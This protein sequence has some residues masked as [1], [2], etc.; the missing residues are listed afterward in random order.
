MQMSDD[1]IPSQT[2][3]SAIP[4]RHLSPNR[5][6]RIPSQGNAN[7]YLNDEWVKLNGA[8]PIPSNQQSI[9]QEPITLS[10]SSPVL[11]EDDLE[12][13]YRAEDIDDPLNSLKRF[14]G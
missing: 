3:T 8:N 10:S 4:L 11:G 14:L 7:K 1:H 13:T 5:Q 9:P 2:V 6:L 12:S